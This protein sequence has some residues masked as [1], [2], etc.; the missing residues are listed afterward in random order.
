WLAAAPH[1]QF[2]SHEA[3]DHPREAGRPGGV[4]LGRC[5]AVAD[6]RPDPGVAGWHLELAHVSLAR[7]ARGERRLLRPPEHAYL[8]EPRHP[9]FHAGHL[10]PARILHRRTRGADADD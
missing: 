1:W 9:Q 10:Q 5:V 6:T 3:D 2:Q 4:R 7:A 8:E